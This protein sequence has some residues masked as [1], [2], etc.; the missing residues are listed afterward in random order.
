MSRSRLAIALVCSVAAFSSATS[1]RADLPPPDGQKF[2][3]YGF[4]VANID[5]YAK[6]YALLAYP[7]GTSSGA[8]IAEMAEIQAGANISVGRRGGNCQ[9]Y[10]M[11]RADFE[12]WKKQGDKSENALDV[13]FKSSKVRSCTGGPNI[14]HQL[15]KSDSRDGITE[16]LKISKLDAKD[17]VIAAADVAPPT[18][19]SAT[20]ATPSATPADTSS[21][22]KSDPPPPVEPGCS[23]CSVGS[24]PFGATGIAALSL[25][26]MLV[27]RKRTRRSTTDR[28]E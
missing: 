20:P 21:T 22:G 28:S 3:G 12:A 6:D 5:A 16:T 17:C 9:L 18:Q 23:R 7:C 4:G 25:V 13:L 27:F 10:V 2:V 14:R 19:M 24:A 26:A 15:P 1:A 8:P 11:A